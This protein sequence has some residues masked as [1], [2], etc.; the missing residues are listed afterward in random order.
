M[1]M[2]IVYWILSNVEKEKSMLIMI[3]NKV[4]TIKGNLEVTPKVN[5][6]SLSKENRGNIGGF[7]DNL[8]RFHCVMAYLGDSE[9]NAQSAYAPNTYVIREKTL[10]YFL[11]SYN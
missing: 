3:Q 7:D 9:N 2:C 1:N 8:K 11:F 5:H 4:D 10:K 6:W